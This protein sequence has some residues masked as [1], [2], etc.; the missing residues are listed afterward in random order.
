VK[1]EVYSRDEVM[2]IGMINL[3]FSNRSW[4]DNRVKC[5]YSEEVGERLS[6][7]G[8]RVEWLW[9]LVRLHYYNWRPWGCSKPRIKLLVSRRNNLTINL[10]TFAVEVIHRLT[11]ITAERCGEAFLGN[12]TF[13]G[14]CTIHRNLTTRSLQ[15]KWASSS[16]WVK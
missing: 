4:M 13:T 12:I 9:E 5:E 2:H 14:D 6:H 8:K 1:Q 7:T 16:E 11:V 10:A 3:W 15:P